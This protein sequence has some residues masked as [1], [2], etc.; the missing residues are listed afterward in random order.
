MASWS[1]MF[2]DE[3]W[4]NHFRDSIGRDLDLPLQLRCPFRI[5]LQQI[6]V[7]F[8]QQT[9]IRQR[10]VTTVSPRLDVVGV[11]IGSGP[12]ATRKHTT[13][14]PHMQ[15]VADIGGDQALFAAHIEH[16]GGA[17]QDDG[18]DAG[19]TGVLPQLARGEHGAV[20]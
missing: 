1:S 2:V 20:G 17:A 19:I 3:S 8:T 7:M 11:A 4:W 14:V 9:Q 6:V 18:Q 12:V 16:T 5:W 15:G 10:C 13:L